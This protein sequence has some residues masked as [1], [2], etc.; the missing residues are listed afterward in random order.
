VV[1]SSNPIRDL[2]LMMA[3]TPVGEK[4]LTLA[5]RGLA[6]IDGTISTAIG[7]ALARTSSR[8]IAYLGDLTF[9]HDANGLLIG[10]HEPRPDL[11]IVV[12]SDDGG[13]I[14]STLEPG[15]DTY[16]P[17]FE[18]VFGTPTRADIGDLCAA[19]G[20]PHT[21]VATREALREALGQATDGIRVV[22]ATL[23]RTRRRA[24]ANAVNGLALR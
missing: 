18:R 8:A 4:R 15:E 11:T 13:S 21:R 12:A 6:G 14:F 22:E 17:A 10:P 24:L 2:D 9:L 1:G 23:D 19:Y 5:N 16:A 3:P 20:I 7:A